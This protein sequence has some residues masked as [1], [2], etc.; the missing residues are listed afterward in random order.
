VIYKE[1]SNCDTL[2]K[3]ATSGLSN[4]QYR[5]SGFQEWLRYFSIYFTYWA[6]TI[7]HSVLV[8]TLELYQI[9]IHSRTRTVWEG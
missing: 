7:P 4:P 2:P 1:K 5:N 3:H 9:I 6:P 8:I